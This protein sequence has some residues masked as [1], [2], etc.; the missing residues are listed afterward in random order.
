MM[1]SRLDVLN[2]ILTFSTF[3]LVFDV[4]I[5]FVVFGVLIFSTNQY[6]TPS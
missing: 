3:F 4:L 5:F 6:I 1:F 2:A